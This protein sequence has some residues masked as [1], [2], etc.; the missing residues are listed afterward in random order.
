MQLN[1]TNNQW[2]EHM[3]NKLG[4]VD[5]ITPKNVGKLNQQLICLLSTNVPSKTLLELLTIKINY[6]SIFPIIC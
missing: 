3:N 4:F 6:L 1:S 2:S 5:Y